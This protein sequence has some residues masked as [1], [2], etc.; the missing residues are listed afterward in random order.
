RT[1][2]RR[3]ALWQPLVRNVSGADGGGDRGRPRGRQSTRIGYD[4]SRPIV[5]MLWKM[6]VL[7]VSEWLK[8]YRATALSHFVIRYE[9]ATSAPSV[10]VSERSVLTWLR[11]APKTTRNDRSGSIDK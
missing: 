3:E 6:A 5:K 11:M 4:A 1:E 7:S 9:A 8:R 10:V 2:G